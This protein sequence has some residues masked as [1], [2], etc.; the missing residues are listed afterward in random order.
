ML[1]PDAITKNIE[2]E[3]LTPDSP[4]VIKGNA[5]AIGIL[6]RNIVDNAIRY[7]P[8]NSTVQIDIQEN[9]QQVILTIRDNGPGI[10]EALRKR[11]FER[12]FRVIGTQS[13]GSGL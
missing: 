2:L 9:D 10:P 1:A 5:I 13:T 4:S 6:I 7:S 8:E 11:V 3:L 12:F